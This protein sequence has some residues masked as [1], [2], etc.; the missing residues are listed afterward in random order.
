MVLF[1]ARI[2]HKYVSITAVQIYEVHKFVVFDLSSYGYR[3]GQWFES[4]AGLNFFR[5]DFHYCLKSALYCEDRA[6]ISIV[7]VSGC[8]RSCVMRVFH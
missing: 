2:A 6:Q 1:T 7:R 4:L 3:R 8:I 5:S